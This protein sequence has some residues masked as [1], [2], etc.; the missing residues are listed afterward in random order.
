MDVPT[1]DPGAVAVRLGVEPP[2]DD[3]AGLLRLAIE[4]EGRALR[5]RTERVAQRGQGSPA[6][7]LNRELAA[8]EQEH[9]GLLE[10]ELARRE[11]WVG[12][13]V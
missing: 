6:W 7:R 9:V 12:G 1:A 10:P 4:P 11:R 2:M 8:E 5:I 13:V 3:P